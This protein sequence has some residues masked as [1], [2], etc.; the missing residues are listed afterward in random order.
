MWAAISGRCAVRIRRC[1]DERDP[2]LGQ[3]Q[4]ALRA[5]AE[6]VFE[7][8]QRRVVTRRVVERGLEIRDRL[9]GIDRGGGRNREDQDVH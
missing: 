1:R 8:A 6:H 3:M 5:A 7:R 9:F 2:A 4:L